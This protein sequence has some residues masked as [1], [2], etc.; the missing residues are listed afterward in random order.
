M[1]F[2]IDPQRATPLFAQLADSVRAEVA[3]GRLRVGER[4]PSAR[5]LA[6]ALG[7][8]LHTVL[9]AYQSLRDEGIVHMHRGRGAVV[10]PAAEGLS[11]LQADLVALMARARE[12]G[13]SADAVASLLRAAAAE[14][15][16]PKETPS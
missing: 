9:H 4:L 6:A 7:V 16:E 13:L 14:P 8:N 3:A 15:A 11:L 2:R 5:E 1:L 12:L 10:A